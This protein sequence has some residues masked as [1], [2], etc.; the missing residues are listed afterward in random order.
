MRPRRPRELTTKHLPT[1][2]AIIRKA[3]KT[4]LSRRHAGDTNAYIVEELPVGRG[5]SRVDMAVI[6]GHIE[7]VEFKSSLD[8]LAR[9]PRQADRFGTAIEKMTLVVAPNHLEEATKIIPEWWTILETRR[10]PR[11]GVSFKRIRQGKRNPNTSAEGY[12]NLLQ[13]EEIVNLLAMHDLDQGVR[14]APWLTIANLAI[15]S[16]PVKQLSKDVRLILK[17]RAAA[18]GHYDTESSGTSMAE[19]A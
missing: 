3:F 10:G 5:D 15:Q 18:E 14:S 2:D 19:L 9:L 13:R 7:G 1:T 11:D 12:L 4:R 16:I 6:N 17:A 8:T